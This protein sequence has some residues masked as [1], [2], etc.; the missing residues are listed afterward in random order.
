MV[1]FTM[2]VILKEKFQIKIYL[3]PHRAPP[4]TTTPKT[5]MW[6]IVIIPAEWFMQCEHWLMELRPSF[7]CI[8]YTTSREIDQYAVHLSQVIS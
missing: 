4:P 8:S 7:K 5:Q 2:T 1:F 6:E 3:S